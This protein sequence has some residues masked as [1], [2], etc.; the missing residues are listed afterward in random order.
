MAMKVAK[1]KSKQWIL[2]NYLNTI[3]LGDGAYGVEAAAQTYYGKNVPQLDVAQ[4]AVIA[5]IIQQPSTYPLP[6]YHAQL[7]SRWHYVLNGMVQMGKLTAPAGRRDEV[8][9]ARHLRPADRRQRCLGP[10]R[11]EH[12]LQR[13]DRRLPLQPVADLQRRLRH[14][15]HASTTPRWQ[16]LYQAVRDNEAQIDAEQRPVRPHLHARGRGARGPRR[17][18]P[19]RPCTPGRATRDRS[20]TG[21][22]RSSPRATA[23]RSP[24][25]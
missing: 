15:Y 5:A 10:L 16:A 18:A 13:A 12:G 8:P 2:T 11:P 1:E 22:A 20:T 6:Q 24:A 3:Y 23:R 17:P 4:A 25:K 9:R 21:R 7:V 19:S 14:P